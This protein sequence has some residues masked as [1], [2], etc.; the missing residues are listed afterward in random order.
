MLPT[1]TRYTLVAGAAEAKEEL[2]AFDKALLN[3]GVGNVNLLRVSSILPPGAKYEPHFQAPAG[4]L[5]PIAYGTLTSRE[6][7]AL[8]AAAVGVGVSATGFGVIMEFAGYCGKEEAEKKVRE[9]VEE[10]F[11]CRG[12]NLEELKVVGIEHRV[13]SCGCVFAGVPLWY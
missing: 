7:G 1:P 4:S 3:A 8:I 2:N 11:Q 12:I 9:M 10:A 13:V 6:P 5:I